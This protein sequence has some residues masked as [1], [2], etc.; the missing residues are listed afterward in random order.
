MLLEKEA[1]CF[2]LPKLIS[3]LKTI[4]TKMFFMELDKL[5]IRYKVIELRK[6]GVGT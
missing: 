2:S 6:H 4:P 5:I 3:R 1:K